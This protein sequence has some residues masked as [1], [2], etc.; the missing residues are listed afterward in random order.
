MAETSVGI[1]TACMPSM[2]LVAQYLRGDIKSNSIPSIPQG[3]NATIG[4][5]G[6]SGPGNRRIHEHNIGM[7]SLDEEGSEYGM[8][9]M[10]GIAKSTEVL[11]E[12][13][14]AK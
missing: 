7:I 6:G 13:G 1:I 2:M 9:E 12:P 11:V 10:G 3:E 8:T 4:G 14:I 5:S